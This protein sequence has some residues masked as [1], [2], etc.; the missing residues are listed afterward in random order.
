MAFIMQFLPSW[1]IP[2]HMSQ[3]HHHEGFS[4]PSMQLCHKISVGTP[5]KISHRGFWLMGC[6]LICVVALCAGGV[7]EH[8]DQGAQGNKK[9]RFHGASS[10]WVPEAC[11]RLQK[12][13][14]WWAGLDTP[15]QNGY[16]LPMTKRVT[17][18]LSLAGCCLVLWAGFEG[19]LPVCLLAFSQTARVKN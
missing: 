10:P 7:S 14:Q 15:R 18:K 9:T 2:D 5:V 11:G 6:L 1:N 8:R 19:M 4:G 3:V 16:S 12:K 13:E 17:L